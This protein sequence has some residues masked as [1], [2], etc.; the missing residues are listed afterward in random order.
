MTPLEL[1]QKIDRQL[2]ILLPEQLALVSAFLDTL[3]SIRPLRKLTPIKRGK[4]AIDLLQF[5]ET[6]QGDDLEKC[7]QFVRDNRTQAEF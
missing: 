6:W 2:E 1:R 7:R 5:A 3:Q 4:K